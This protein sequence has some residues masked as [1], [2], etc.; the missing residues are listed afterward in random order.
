MKSGVPALSGLLGYLATLALIAVIYAL[1]ITIVALAAVFSS[2]PSR[3]KAALEV[4]RELL[5]SG[6]QGQPPDNDPMRT[7]PSRPRRKNSRRHPPQKG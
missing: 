6:H 7:F 3:R 5:P 2:K 1:L 4:L